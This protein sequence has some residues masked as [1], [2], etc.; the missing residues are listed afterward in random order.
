MANNIV[1][2]AELMVFF[3]GKSIAYATS[4]TLT[5]SGETTDVSSKDHGVWGASEVNKVTWEITSENL[6]TEE[7]YAELFE[8]MVVNMKDK[9]KLVWGKR[10]EATDDKTVVDG[11]YPNWTAGSTVYSG[12]AYI[13]SLTT[14]ANN[15]ENATFSVTFTGAGKIAT[16]AGAGD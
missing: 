6:Y 5:L 13:T 4:H 11:D 10:A 7:A 3:K 15:G 9:V 12:D 16:G 14:N 1:K 8:Q 2:G